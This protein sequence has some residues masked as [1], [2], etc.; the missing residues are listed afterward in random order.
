V[1]RPAAPVPAT[2]EWLATL[3]LYYL[4]G[5]AMTS[6]VDQPDLADI[7]TDEP[8][9][10][11]IVRKDDYMRGYVLGEE[12]EALCGER[13]IPTRDPERYPTCGGCKAAIQNIL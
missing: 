5:V 13:F 7:R 6:V 3:S 11:H 4:L 1:T 12:I 2:V 10:A 8:K 9:I